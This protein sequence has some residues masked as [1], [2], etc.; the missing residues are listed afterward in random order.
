[1]AHVYH[2]V[3]ERLR[4]VQDA[5]QLLRLSHAHSGLRALRLDDF[6]TRQRHPRLTPRGPADRGRKR[7]KPLVLAMKTCSSTQLGP[8]RVARDALIRGCGTTGGRWRT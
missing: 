5:R 3:V 1:M 2:Q 6:G 8:D 4:N 7:V